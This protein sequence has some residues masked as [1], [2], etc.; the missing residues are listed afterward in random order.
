MYD[1][2]PLKRL[3]VTGPGAAALLQR[4]TT[5]NVDKSVG[6]VTYTLLLDETGGIRSDLTVAR[7]GANHFQVGANGNLDLDWLLRHVPENGSVQVRDIT[8]GTCCIGLWGPL[9]RE[10]AQ[11]L[12]TTDLSSFG[13]FRGVRTYLGNVP[14]TMLRL[15]YVGE[16]G[17][18]IYTTAELGLRLWDT[19]W[20]AGAPLGVVA[21]GRSAFNSLRLEK[22][23][24]S[25]GTDMT[26]EHNPYEAGVGFA[27]RMNKGP[28]VGR[29]A[30]EGVSDQTVGRKLTCLT[31]DDRGAMVMGKEPVYVDGAPAGYV[32]SAAYGYTIDAP[33]AYAWLPASASVPGTAVHIEYFGEKVAATVAAEP[34]FDPQSARMRS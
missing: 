4:L 29:E 30:L 28:F 26:D 27:V 13:Y 34:L 33:I 22:G 5:N 15:S 10:V 7:L 2:T 25:W 3:E 32:T 18:E 20:E 8:A 31:L 14:V 9:A 6:S 1:M 17:W 19:L 21:G 11:P 24:R 16:L 23:Y 12:T